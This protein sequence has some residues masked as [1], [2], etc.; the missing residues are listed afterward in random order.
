MTHV[1]TLVTIVADLKSSLPD[2]LRGVLKQLV[3]TLT[4]LEVQ[5]TALDA[6]INRRSK[7]DPTARRLMT[8]PG[9]GLLPRRQSPR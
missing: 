9:V 4:A 7:S 8:T 3:D 5:I 6:E 1:E 2:S